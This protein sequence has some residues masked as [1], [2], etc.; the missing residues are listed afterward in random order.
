MDRFTNFRFLGIWLLVSAS[1]LPIHAEP[2]AGPEIS[3]ALVGDSTVAEWAEAKPARGW[4]QALAPFL[5]DDVKI[6]NLAVSGASTKTFPATGNWQKA[7]DGNPT[8]I[9]IQF[10]HN[11]SHAPGLPES[12]SADG[13]YTENLRRYVAEARAAG[14]IPVLITPMHRRMFDSTGQPTRELEPYAMAAREVAAREQVPL[15]DL[16]QS[17]GDLLARLGEAGS[18]GLTVSDKDRT[19]FTPEGAA[20]MAGLVADGLRKGPSELARLVKP[21]PALP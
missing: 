4:G 8:F 10:G 3:L 7:L 2:V 15:I 9:L 16:Y 5:T 1:L 12:T 21:A 11:D 6:V 20:V 17:S 18:A 13:E 14:S 19:H